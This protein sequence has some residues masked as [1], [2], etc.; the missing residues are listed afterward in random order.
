MRFESWREV[1]RAFPLYVRGAMLISTFILLPL[2]VALTLYYYG[3]EGSL[4]PGF[5][6]PM[7]V[8][9]GGIGSNIGSVSSRLGLKKQKYFAYA[10]VCIAGALF[11]LALLRWVGLL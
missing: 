5:L 2:F 7:S 11:T 4:K 10:L 3:F 6:G 1:W 8:Y 9:L